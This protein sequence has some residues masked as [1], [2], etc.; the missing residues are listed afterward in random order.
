MWAI[1]TALID[2]NAR[3]CLVLDGRLYPFAALRAELR[4]ELPATT[5]ALFAD[6]P[7]AAA[8]LQNE[9]IMI[10]AGQ[11]P[12][13]LDASATLLAPLLPG[14][15]LCAGANYYDHMAEMGFPGVKKE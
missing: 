7:A 2:G 5:T 3:P 6:W 13:P 11:G 12:A 14:K 4:A 8:K 1:A 10:A 9:A 15:V